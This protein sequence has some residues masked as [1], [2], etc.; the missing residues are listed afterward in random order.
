MISDAPMSPRVD[1]GWMGRHKILAVFVGAGAI[2]LLAVGILALGVGLLIAGPVLLGRAVISL[3]VNKMKVCFSPLGNTMQQAKKSLWIME[4][5]GTHPVEEKVYGGRA[6][7]LIYGN[8]M[9]FRILGPFVQMPVVSRL[10]G[11]L[12][13]RPSSRE[14]IRPF[15]E[16]FGI[17]ETEFAR[18]VDS[19]ESFNG[20]F[21]RALKPNAR[22]VAE[23]ERVVVMPADGR[24]QVFND[25]SAHDLFCVKGMRFNVRSFLGDEA[26]ER[27]FE[28]GSMVIARINP[29]DYHRFHCPVSGTLRSVWQA[30]RRLLSVN[31]RALARRPSILWEN[32]REC[33]L[34]HSPHLG[35]VAVV[36]VGATCVGTIHPTC[37][38]RAGANYTKGQE[39]GY[40]S[41]GGS[42]VVLLFE[43][44]RVRF[45]ADLLEHT[46]RGLET[47][48][49][50][51]TS[52]GTVYEP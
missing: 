5:G 3:C 11:W 32:K 46:S 48:C 23:G 27:K 50:Y 14:R 41:F 45:D 51:G 31:P 13:Q 1:S 7:S 21:T 33:T 12:Q 30:G 26:L 16:Q 52:L 15:I 38:Q 34:I 44:G 22:P 29:T 2:S 18:S 8:G 9:I 47:K 42:S 36:A 28:H 4:R 40:F 20:F 35:D 10:Y 37:D 49:C 17:D 39:M 25:V 24:Y 43:P 19:F 6:L